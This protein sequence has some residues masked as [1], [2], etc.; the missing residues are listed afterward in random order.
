MDA[1]FRTSVR[2]A[3]GDRAL[4]LSVSGRIDH[5]NADAFS[6]ALEPVLSRCRAGD[7]AVVLDLAGLEYVSSAGLRCFMLAAR[8]T[9]DQSGRLVVAAPTPKVREIFE[10]TRFTLLFDCLATVDE[11]LAAAAVPAGA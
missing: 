4:V 6:T 9:K 3:A 11:A 2:P 5:S 10:I 8:Q 1:T 7:A